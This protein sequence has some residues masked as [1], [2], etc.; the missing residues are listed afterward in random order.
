[1]VENEK[2]KENISKEIKI[3]TTEEVGVKRKEK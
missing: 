2:F 1:M 3:F